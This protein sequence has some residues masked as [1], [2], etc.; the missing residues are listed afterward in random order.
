MIELTD[1]ERAFLLQVLKQTTI[2][3]LD[4]MRI[5]LAIAAKLGTKERC[6]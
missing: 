1:E 3:G 5:L 2:T 6:T 4:G